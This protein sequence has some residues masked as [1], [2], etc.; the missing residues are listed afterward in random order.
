[1]A[2]IEGGR[3]DD[4]FW[5]KF[6]T[7]LARLHQHSNDNFGLDHDNYMGALEQSNTPHDDWTAFFVEERLEPQVKLARDNNEID[8]SHVRLFSQ[9]Y[10]K[11]DS[12]F[13]PEQPALIHGDLWSGNYMVTADNEP[14]L[15]DPA[16]YYGHREAELAMTQ[17]FGRFAPS[18]YEHY[19]NEFPLESGWQER[20]DVYKIYPLMIHVNLFGAGGYLSQ[21]E[22]ILRHFV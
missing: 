3:E 2:Y 20:L 4:S 16:A 1:M 17:M 14:C 12:I 13:P 22:Q 10:P 6:G 7:R 21:T 9:L 15:I 8:S 18:F 11:L 5:Q 19:H